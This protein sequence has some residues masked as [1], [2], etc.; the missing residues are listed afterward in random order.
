MKLEKVEIKEIKVK[1][2]LEY[3]KQ[4]NNS[5]WDGLPDVSSQ[6]VLAMIITGKKVEDIELKDLKETLSRYTHTVEEIQK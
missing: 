3:E 5:F 2:M 1:D 4:T 6:G